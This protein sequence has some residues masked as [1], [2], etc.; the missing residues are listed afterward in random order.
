M[1]DTITT[2]TQIAMDEVLQGRRRGLR[3]VLPFLGP[4]ELDAEGIEHH[5][6]DV[7]LAAFDRFLTAKG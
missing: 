1:A 4:A 3:A 7:T 2:R 6:S 5:V